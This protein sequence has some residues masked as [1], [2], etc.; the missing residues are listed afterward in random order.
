MIETE[1]VLVASH[2]YS[3]ADI[4]FLGG[5]PL[6][7][8]IL[9]GIALVG[10]IE[11][12]LNSYLRP[13]G[14]NIKNCY[15]STFIKE[16]LAYS[17]TNIKLLKEALNNVDL[18]YY[19]EVLLQELRDIN[20]TVIIPLD[21]IALG[22]VYPYISTISKPRSRKY[23][24]YCYRGSVLPLRADWI[25]SLGSQIKVIP[26]VGPQLLYSDAT[27]RSYTQ[28][29]FQKIAK[30][31]QNRDI[32]SEGIVW[33]CRRY[34]EFD[35]FLDRQWKKEPKRVTFDIETYGGL[36]TCISFCFDGW[37]AVSVPM[38]DYT[39]DK[40]ERVL[41]WKRIAKILSSSLEKNNQNIKYDWIILERHGFYLN[42][43]TSD[44]MLKGALIY[45]ELPKGLDFYTSIY[46]NIPYYKDEGKEFDPKKHDKD[47]LYLYNAKDSLAA[48]IVSVEEDKEL[49]EDP[50]A[51]QLYNN[52][53]A[54]SILIYKNLDNTGLLVD[55]EVKHKK[56]EKYHR[57]YDNNEFILRSLV[58]NKEFNARSPKQ[59]GSL[60]YDQLG[61][62]LRYKTNE[63][64]VKSFKT[65]KDTLDDLLIHHGDDQK[66]GKIGYNILSRIIVCRKLA[67]VVEYLNTPLH[68]DNTFR[69]SYNLSG[70]ETGRS[71]CSKTI[72][73]R[74][75]TSDDPNSTKATKRLGRSLQ[76][77]SKHGFAID[78]EIFN[79]F[80]DAEI[81][82]DM[83]EI[84]IPPHNFIFI[85]GDGAG[86][87]ARVVF[88]LAEDYENLANMDLKPKIHAKTA[89]A[90]FNMD[91]N[92]ITSK[93]PAIPKVG[94]TY[95]DLGKKVRHAG[96]Y[97]MGAFRMAQM[98][99]LP[100]G[101]C[102]DALEKFH[103]RE[104][105]LKDVFHK[106]IEDIIRR[107]RVLRTPWGRSR[108]FYA[109]YDESLLKEA[110][111][112]IPQSTISDLTKFTMWRI[113]DQLP[114]YMTEYKFNSEQHDS[115][116][117]TVH[118]DLKEKYLETF[119]RIYERPINFLNCSLSRDFELVIP[120]ELFIGEANWMNMVE[121]K[122]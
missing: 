55:N 108:T 14:I 32:S 44:S 116:L 19:E 76:T 78:E 85:E 20:P 86:A 113:A 33:V 81:A 95:Y 29:D 101:F 40:Y 104:P 54:P 51:K 25:L 3:D 79:D 72:D 109:K 96:N 97:L 88:V 13:H 43:V 57:L 91:A 73:E 30:E 7:D 49:E 6:K 70:T 9:N 39:L 115:I 107:T 110:I 82:S 8:D 74:F 56:L 58:G 4:F 112:Y 102:I 1:K 100:L 62:P 50:Y 5:H 61:F 69:G 80:D 63:F 11:G 68:P 65:D 41:F 87:E 22:V 53:I 45:P 10:S 106:E 67:K 75:R 36:I 17:G 105:Q 28:L 117:A 12:T 47:R 99:H 103:A 120:T 37:E 23:W 24:V 35:R 46:T 114:G 83:R 34:E 111:A 26:I 77:I 118:K 21:D 89:A 48:H 94:I 122:I 27:A 16:K 71:S 64:G 119:K 42:N 98:T 52:E 60:I 2:G 18:K 121:V 90:I 84:F 31:R 66:T 92:L 15:R 93:G 38:G 59:V